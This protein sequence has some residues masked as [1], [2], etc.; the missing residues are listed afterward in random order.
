MLY[1]Y[2]ISDVRFI[3]HGITVPNKLKTGMIYPVL[4]LNT[5]TLYFYSICGQFLTPIGYQTEL[6][7]LFSNL[8]TN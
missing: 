6:Q 8:K 4:E 2:A 1:N 5:S 7:P 3:S